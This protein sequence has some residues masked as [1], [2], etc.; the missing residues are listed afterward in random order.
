MKTRFPVIF[1]VLLCLICGCAN[2]AVIYQN[3]SQLI[4]NSDQ[5][6]H[7]KIVAVTSAWNPQK[8]HIETTAQILVDESFVTSNN[9]TITPG[10]DYSGYYPWRDSWRYV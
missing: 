8:T 4:L 2:A 6:V 10:S 1:F 3:D 5:I 9:S 7:G